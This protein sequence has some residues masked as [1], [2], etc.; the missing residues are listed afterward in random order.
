MLGKFNNV[1]VLPIG[2]L[3]LLGLHDFKAQIPYGGPINTYK[4]HVSRVHFMCVN[5]NP[6]KSVFFAMLRMLKR[7]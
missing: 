4:L 7:I 3:W 6:N 5:V 2:T 1:T